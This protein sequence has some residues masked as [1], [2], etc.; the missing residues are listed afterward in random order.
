MKFRLRQD[1]NWVQTDE[2]KEKL[3][4]LGFQFI[5]ETNPE[6]RRGYGKWRYNSDYL[7]EI[8]INSLE[9]L[10]KIVEKYEQIIITKDEIEIY[11]YYRE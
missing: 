5:A 11:N 7:P 3:E 4:E 6:D 2:E 1:K 9:E 10:M 8:E